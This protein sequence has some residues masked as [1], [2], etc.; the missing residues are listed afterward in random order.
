M[1]RVMPS[2]AT[3]HSSCTPGPAPI[4]LRLRTR[5]GAMVGSIENWVPPQSVVASTLSSAIPVAAS[6]QRTGPS[7][8]TWLTSPATAAAER[9][10]P[11]PGL[12]PT[13]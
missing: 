8:A 13:K 9:S 7:Q 6:S 11:D 10:E 3:P 12:V 4:S 1:A 5:T 2:G